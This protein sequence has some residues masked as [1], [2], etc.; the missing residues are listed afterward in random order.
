MVEERNVGFQV[1]S[2][3]SRPA[4][5]MGCNEIYKPVRCGGKVPKYGTVP[6]L[7]FGVFLES[8]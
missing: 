7:Q 8:F 3:A 2:L 5:I 6:A 1:F 4:E